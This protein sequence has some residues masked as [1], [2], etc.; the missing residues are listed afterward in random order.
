VPPQRVFAAREHVYM[1]AE[2]AYV[3]VCTYACVYVF[4]FELQIQF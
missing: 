3:C 1:Y 4:S 2:E